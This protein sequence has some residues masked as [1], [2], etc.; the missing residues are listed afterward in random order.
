VTVPPPPLHELEAEIMDEVW[1]RDACTVREVLD[2][3]NARSPTP[4]AYTT[5]MTVM[6][7][8]DGKGLLQRERD[9][10]RDVYVAALSRDEYAQARAGAQV[11][12]L[13]DEYGDVAL[14]HFARHMS[15]LDPKRREQIRRLAGGD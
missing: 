6:Q 4:R 9:G 13:V 3:L 10:R 11:G 8:L 7:R 15:Q 14:A 1:A 2:A 5:V 12:A